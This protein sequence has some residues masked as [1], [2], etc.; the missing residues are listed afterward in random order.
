MRRHS[1]KSF[2]RIWDCLDF[3][4]IE[5]QLDTFFT[6]HQRKDDLEQIVQAIHSDKTQTCDACL[7]FGHSIRR[8][9][10][11][12]LALQK[13]RSSQVYNPR[14]KNQLGVYANSEPFDKFTDIMIPQELF[15]KGMHIWTVH[16]F[17]TS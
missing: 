4:N 5:W 16:T 15:C 10:Q 13:R 6:C 9:P 3:T 11:T 7:Q 1:A 14:K 2:Y 17:P 12:K 8:Y